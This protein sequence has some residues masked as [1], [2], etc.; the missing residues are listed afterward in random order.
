MRLRTRVRIR[1]RRLDRELAI[2]CELVSADH[3]LRARQLMDPATRR[4]LASSLR[5]VVAEAERSQAVVFSSVPV[6]RATVAPWR[7]GLLGLAE[8]LTAPEPLNPCGVARTL[9]LLSDGTGPLFNPASRR[10]IA[11]MVW[12]IADGLQPCPPHAWGCPKVMKLDPEHV[13]WTCER[14]GAIAMTSDP[15]VRPT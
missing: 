6:C 7:E 12:W 9:E 2:G 15:A 4:R 14:C 1:R 13:A 5:R 3:S 8:A 11:E 10:S